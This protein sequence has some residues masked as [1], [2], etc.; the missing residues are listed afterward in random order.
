GSTGA[1]G[2]GMC[3]R[4]RR[5]PPDRPRV[6]VRSPPPRSLVSANGGPICS[7]IGCFMGQLTTQH[8]GD[9]ESGQERLKRVAVA[10]RPDDELFCGFLPACYQELPE[11]DLAERTDDDLYALAQAHLNAGRVRR[12]GETVIKVL[13]PDRDRDGWSS[14]RSIVI[15]VTDDAPFL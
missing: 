11:F 2:V 14:D 9:R 12:P 6:R 10:R 1:G 4:A 15:L 3:A 8:A 7:R 13:S 5:A